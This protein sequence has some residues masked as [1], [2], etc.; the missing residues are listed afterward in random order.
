V[1]KLEAL[2]KHLGFN[3][4]HE[5]SLYLGLGRNTIYNI[6]KGD[7]EIG[8]NVIKT[9]KDKYPEFNVNFFYTR[10]AEMFQTESVREKD[11][12]K[13][14]GKESAL[15]QQ[16]KEAREEE[17]R[18]RQIISIA[19]S[20][21]TIS[22]KHLHDKINFD[23]LVGRGVVKLMWTIYMISKKT[24]ELNI[25]A[26]NKIL[27]NILSFINH[28]F[29]KFKKVVDSKKTEHEKLK[30]IEEISKRLN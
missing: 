2:R 14:Y 18:L 9:I 23:E 17:E 4:A 7:R 27:A 22:F 26:A 11:D 29:E 24:T 8:S 10:D 21:K 30:L 16:L 28:V 5:F 3:D 1:N 19:F 6:E 15:E 12:S 13:L 25:P 20:S